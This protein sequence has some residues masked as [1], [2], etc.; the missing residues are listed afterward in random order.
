MSAPTVFN[1]LILQIKPDIT[2]DFATPPPKEY[3]VR[4]TRKSLCDGVCWQL[5]IVRRPRAS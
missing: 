5:E 4:K 1:L 2:R 3:L